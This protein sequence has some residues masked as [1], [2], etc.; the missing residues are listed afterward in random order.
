MATTILRHRVHIWM[1]VGTAV[2]VKYLKCAATGFGCWMFKPASIRIENNIVSLY[3][4]QTG[5]VTQYSF[6][7]N[8]SELR[9][10]DA[11]GRVLSFRL[12]PDNF[13]SYS[14]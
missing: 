11:T 6:I 9:L 8:R 2:P 1:A 12:R 7:R 3:S 14:F 5:T 13:G 4:P 10:Q